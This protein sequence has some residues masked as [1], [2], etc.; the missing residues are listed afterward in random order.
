VAYIISGACFIES[1]VLVADCM[2]GGDVRHG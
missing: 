2:K 1:L